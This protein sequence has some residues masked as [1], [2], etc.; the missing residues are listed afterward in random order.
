MNTLKQKKLLLIIFLVATTFFSVPFLTHARG[1]VPCGGYKD[2]AGTQR[3]NPCNLCDIFSLIAIV[4]NY[5][6]SVA[7][8]YAVFQIIFAGFR[9]VY[10]MGDE[11][12]ITKNKGALSAAVVGFVL[13][14]MAFLLVNTAINYILLDGSPDA[15][16]VTLQNPF[17][18]L[19]GSSKL[20]LSPTTK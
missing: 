14:M 1:L 2:A 6:I 12:S 19:N 17:M 5:L 13:V 16:K 8:I 10:S 3:E 7:G 11:E 9:L 15:A 20:C 18:Y 4:T